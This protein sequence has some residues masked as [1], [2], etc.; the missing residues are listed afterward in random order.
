MVAQIVTAV[1]VSS[2]RQLTITVLEVGSRICLANPVMLRHELREL[3]TGKA[4]IY[5]RVRA[6]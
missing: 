5:C 3:I 2:W 4:D 1:V 6:A